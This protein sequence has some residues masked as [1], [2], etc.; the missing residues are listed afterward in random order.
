MGLQKL[1]VKYGKVIALFAI[2]IT[3]LSANTACACYLHQ[4]ELPQNAGKLRKF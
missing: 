1:A 2:A 4:P 3:T